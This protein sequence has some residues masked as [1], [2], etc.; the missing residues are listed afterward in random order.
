M[1]YI[2]SDVLKVDICHWQSLANHQELTI[3]WGVLIKK[4]K[5]KKGEITRLAFT[6]IC[7]SHL[8]T[9]LSL[10]FSQGTSMDISQWVQICQHDISISEYIYVNKI[11]LLSV[12]SRQISQSADMLQVRVRVWRI[13]SNILVTN[14]YSDIRSYQF[15]FYEYIRT[16]VRVK[17]FERIYSDIC[18]W[19]C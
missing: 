1:Y 14:I 8:G 3:Y 11:F 5:I 13:Y 18:W 12:I 10:S 15:F 7:F 19:V 16:F 4:F 6:I 17:F 9:Q 2:K